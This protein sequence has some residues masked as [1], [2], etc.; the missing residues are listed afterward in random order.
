MHF[1]FKA[2]VDGSYFKSNPVLVIQKENI[3]PG[4]FRVTLADIDQIKNCP[5]ADV[6]HVVGLQQDTFDY[7]VKTY[8]KQFKAI[9]LANISPVKDLSL[10]GTLPQLEYLRLSVNYK[11]SLLWS[12]EG[13]I[14]LTGLCL[15]DF[16]KLSSIR[17]IRTAPA[18]RELDIS[19][20]MWMTMVIDSFKPLSGMRIERL[21]FNGKAIADNDLSFVEH[22]PNLKSFDFPTNMFTTDQVAW[23]VANFPQVEGY[24]LKAMF[25]CMLL[26]SNEN[27]VLVPHVM[28]I[29]KRKPAL[30]IQ[31]NEK[32]IQKYLDNFEKLKAQYRGVPYKEAFSL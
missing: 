10:L 7:F 16:T 9:S 13:N 1:P 32:R 17:E 29:G 28:I 4:D 15:E 25:D 19:N 24:A 26:D 8:G 2:F 18:L 5:D 22:L 30:K 31:G 14:S 23:I 27:R 6:V 12:M 20:H 11:A 21:V 3:M